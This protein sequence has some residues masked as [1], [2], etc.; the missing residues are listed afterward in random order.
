MEQRSV[1][2]WPVG[3]IGL[4]AM[5]LSLED[6]PPR[7][8]ALDTI[9]AALDAGVRLVDT[10]DAYSTGGDDTGHNERLVAEALRTWPG[11]RDEVLVAT[12]GGHVRPGDG[13]WSIDGRPE[14]LRAA[15]E[16]SLRALGV[17]FIEL[18]QLHRPDPAVPFAESIGAL[19]ELR[20]AGKI[21][22]VGLS[23]VTVDQIEEAC[24]VVPIASVQNQFSPAFRS[25][26]GELA[27]C[28]DVG[29]AFLAWAPLGGMG[30]AGDLGSLHRPFGEVARKHAVSPQVVAL[31]WSLAHGEVVIPIPG[32][33]RPATIVDS[34]RAGDLVLDDDDLETLGLAA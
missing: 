3:P 16:G 2:G 12:K 6:R 31:A 24:S 33:T 23:N 4:G 14:H 18:Y 25:S 26:G 34:C 32:S 15:C 19:A 30:A 9:H 20:A 17:E 29:I 28:R 11:P 8:R 21:R 10:A 13:T 7:D 22:R 5:P 27:H 1:G